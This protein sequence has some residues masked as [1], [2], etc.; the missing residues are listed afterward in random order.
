MPSRKS[1]CV[2]GCEANRIN[3]K[4]VSMRVL[5]IKDP[6]IWQD[7]LDHLG[8]NISNLRS[9]MQVNNFVAFRKFI[10]NCNNNTG[11]STL[12]SSHHIMTQ[13]KFAP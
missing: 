1:C 2:P 9:F 6:E 4:K 8:Q 12:A 13:S 11:F 5:P 3:V 10:G 7:F